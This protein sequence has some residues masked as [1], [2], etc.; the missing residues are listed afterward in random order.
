VWDAHTAYT[1]PPVPDAPFPFPAVGPPPAA[2]TSYAR[3]S[4][5]DDG[6]E[7]ASAGAKRGAVDELGSEESEPAPV[8]AARGKKAG[9]PKAERRVRQKTGA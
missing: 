4:G 1:Y 7:P 9:K 2:S 3:A 5:S 8:K 6:S